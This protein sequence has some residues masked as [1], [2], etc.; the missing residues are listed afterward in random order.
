MKRIL[1][2][3]IYASFCIVALLF[4]QTAMAQK[5]RTITGQVFDNAG[6]PMIGATVVVAGNT[7][8]GTTTD[9]QGKYTLVA[10][11]DGVLSVSFIGY[12]EQKVAINGK[13]L[14]NIVLAEAAH[15]MDD[16]IVTAYGEAKREA[17]TGSAVQIKSEEIV[18]SQHT[19]QGCRNSIIHSLCK[20]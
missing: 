15:A 14:V 19:N 1:S 5:A 17:F 12:D 10:P 18:K 6:Q 20:Q 4:A 16:V 13:T 7:N 3:V 8:V 11:V 9:A 2:S